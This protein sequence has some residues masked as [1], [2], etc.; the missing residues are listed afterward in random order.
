MKS[1]TESPSVAE[2]EEVDSRLFVN[3]VE[4]AMRVFRAFVGQP[5]QQSIAEIAK[6]TGIGRSATQRLVYTLE[7]LG[8]LRR[9]ERTRLYRLAPRVLEFAS[10]YF[11]NDSIILNA[12]PCFSEVCEKSGES[13]TLGQLDDTEIFV[14]ARA[15]GRHHYGGEFVIGTRYTAF[16]CAQGRAI[17][18]FLPRDQAMDILDRSDIHPYTA[19]TITDRQALLDELDRV[20]QEGCAIAVEEMQEGTISAAVPVFGSTGAPIA[21]VNVFSLAARWSEERMREELVPLLRRAADMLAISVGES[22]PVPGGGR[23]S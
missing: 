22:M 1:E 6:Q 5:S 17:L 19:H 12:P 20:R 23:A 10:S 3:S 8:Y 11:Q 13:V 4:K 21:G 16:A 14:L 9:D 15:L 18:A 7:K 2:A